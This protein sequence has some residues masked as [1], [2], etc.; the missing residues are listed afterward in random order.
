MTT[1]LFIPVHLRAQ[2]LTCDGRAGL[3]YP[4]ELVSVDQLRDGRLD[5]RAISPVA[6]RRRQ[7]QE[8]RVP[9]VARRPSVRVTTGLRS[10]W[11]CPFSARCA[12]V[13]SARLLEMLPKKTLRHFQSIAHSGACRKTPSAA[14]NR[15]SE[16]RKLLEVGCE[17]RDLSRP[18]G[19]ALH[20]TDQPHGIAGETR[21]RGGRLPPAPD[22]RHHRGPL[23]MAIAGEPRASE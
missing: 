21:S 5:W 15:H 19:C 14:E 12:V 13:C 20:R 7:H 6:R 17:V 4:F 23:L 22:R 18:R 11:R 8:K 16:P 9:Q 2:Q 1:I 3:D 10:T